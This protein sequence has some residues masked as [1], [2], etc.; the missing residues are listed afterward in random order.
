MRVLRCPYRAALRA[1]GCAAHRQKTP[2]ID[3]LVDGLVGWFL[4]IESAV[5]V[6]PFW[7]VSITR[8]DRA[9]KPVVKHK[10]S[11]ILMEGSV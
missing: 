8:R 4:Q 7:R 11:Y 5:V 2:P 1:C 6:A 10:L 3:G 9:T